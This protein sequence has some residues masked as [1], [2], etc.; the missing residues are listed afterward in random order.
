M[1]NKNL[2]Y[3]TLYSVDKSGHAV[4]DIA[5][6]GSED[7]LLDIKDFFKVAKKTKRDKDGFYYFLPWD[8][9]VVFDDGSWLSRNKDVDGR[10][11]WK[12]N[13]IPR[14]PLCSPRHI[15]SLTSRCGVE[16]LAETLGDHCEL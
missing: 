10:C 14:A 13:N 15:T 6:I 12:Y 2:Y 1:Y 9:T 5:T 16:N 3:E 7:V 4:D 11:D 8:L